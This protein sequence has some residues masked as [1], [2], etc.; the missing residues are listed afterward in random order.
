M[1]IGPI[2]LTNTVSGVVL[3]ILLILVGGLAWLLNGVYKTKTEARAA[4]ES[5]QHAEQNTRNV[6]NGFAG[7]VNKKLDH[8]TKQIDVLQ[9]AHAEHLEW[10]M[11]QGEK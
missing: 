5:S 2:T 11:R 1:N 10:H 8:I 4:K 7:S 6:S 3:G 9:N